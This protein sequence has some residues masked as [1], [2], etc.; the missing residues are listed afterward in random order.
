MFGFS[1]RTMG[2][3]C[4]SG[5]VIMHLYL[6]CFYLWGNIAVYI[7]SYLHK[8][9][10][11]VNLDDTSIIFVVQT[12]SQALFMP[13]A[14]FLLKFMPPWSLCI[15]GGVFAIGGV[16][17]ASFMTSY[18]GFV[19]IYPTFF[20]IGVG[21]SYMAPIICGWEYFPTKRGLISGL[22]VGGFGFGSFIFSYIS[23]AVVNPSG[24]EPDVKVD[25]GKIF[26]PDDPISSR[27]PLMIRINCAI[28]TFLLLS[29]VL[30]IRRKSHHG[31]V[32][33]EDDKEGLVDSPTTEEL[34]EETKHKT[35]EFQ[36]IEPS[37][38]SAI[39]DWRTPY[40]WIMIV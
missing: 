19:L 23:L 27:V 26:G 37:F 8:H 9:D 30:I 35:K 40:I 18:I 21:F 4:V 7:T 28:W 31:F 5:G 15:L 13:M 6:G 34:L 11:S 14:P 20:G 36:E 12:I 2:I 24:K 38:L 29:A 16:F 25:G 17:L 10:E 22:I 39:K 33:L 32:E 1:D 3:L